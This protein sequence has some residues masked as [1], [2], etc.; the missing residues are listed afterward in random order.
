MPQPARGTGPVRLC[1]RVDLGAVHVSRY[2]VPEHGG[3]F[4]VV[5]D[6]T[7]APPPPREDALTRITREEADERRAPAY[8]ARMRAMA[9]E[10]K[11]RPLCKFTGNPI[12]GCPSCNG[13]PGPGCQ[14][15]DD[16]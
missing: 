15:K 6:F 16:E 2:T 12:A 9:A 7:G 14:R 1:A 13:N 8:D 5:R 11:L 3:G 4:A 10:R